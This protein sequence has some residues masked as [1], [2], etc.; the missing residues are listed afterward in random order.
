MSLEFSI[1]R[2]ATANAC[3]K[4][5]RSHIRNDGTWLLKGLDM[6]LMHMFILGRDNGICAR[7]KEYCGY[8]G[9][10]DHIIPRG[11]RRNDAPENLQWL[12][13]NCHR[14]KHVRVK[15]TTKG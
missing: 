4:D 11:K 9:E 1:D 2:E 13:P 14:L 8:N 5:P 6:K 10:T 12:C 7:C 3:F 15:W